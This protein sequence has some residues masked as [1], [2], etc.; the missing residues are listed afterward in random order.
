MTEEK[1]E[2]GLWSKNKEGG[3][4]G[5]ASVKSHAGVTEVTNPSFNPLIY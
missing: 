2:A 3:V 5:L 1:G 4:N